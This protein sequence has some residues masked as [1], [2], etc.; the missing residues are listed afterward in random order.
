MPHR[1]KIAGHDYLDVEH[2]QTAVLH[3][4]RSYFRSHQASGKLFDDFP[5]F[6]LVKPIVLKDPELATRAS[7]KLILEDCVQRA[8]QRNGYVGVSKW[9]NP[10]LNYYWLEMA[11]FPFMLGD[12]VTQNNEAEFY[13]LLQQFIAYTQTH[14]KVYGDLVA[15]AQGDADVALMLNGIAQRAA[16]LSKTAG[17]YPIEQLLRFNPNWPLTEVKKLL[18]ALKGSELDWCELFF[19]HIMYVIGHHQRA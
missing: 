10:K 6:F 8:Q 14:P 7:D 3:L 12:E 15:D 9:R 5:D 1:K 17:P 16:R 11:V 4:F 2:N 18:H 19:E 13:Y